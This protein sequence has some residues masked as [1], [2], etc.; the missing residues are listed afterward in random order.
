M[1]M[2]AYIAGSSLPMAL[3]IFVGSYF[4]IW[5]RRKH[6][7]PIKESIILFFVFWLLAVMLIIA[8]KVLLSGQ[9][10]LT[11]ST[12]GNLWGPLIVG[13]IVGRYIV[14]WRHKV[15]SYDAVRKSYEDDGK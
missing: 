14:E 15:N 11:Q 6:K 12:I 8:F 7:L 13:I 1:E 5:K 3:L 9:D 2:I 4:G 10:E